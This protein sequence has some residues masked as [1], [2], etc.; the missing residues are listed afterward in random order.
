VFGGG[1]AVSYEFQLTQTSTLDLSNTGMT[2]GAGASG[3]STVDIDQNTRAVLDL[4]ALEDTGEHTLLLARFR[5]IDSSAVR[6]DAKLQSSF[7]LR[8]SRDCAVDGFAYHQNTPL[9]Y[10]RF[11]QAVAYELQWSWPQQK[12]STL[13]G[14]NSVGAYRARLATRTRDHQTVVDKRVVHYEPWRD[15]LGAAMKVEDS[16]ATVEP[17]AGPWFETFEMRENLSGPNGSSKR[18]VVASRVDSPDDPLADQPSAEGEYVWAD[19]L[20][21]DLALPERQPPSKQELK[22]RAEARKLSVDQAVDAYVGRVQDN[23]TGIQDT[24]PQLSIYLEARPEAAAAIVNRVKRAE[25]PQEAVMGAFIALGNARTEEAKDALDG[26]MEDERAPVAARSQAIL[27]L[28]DRDDVGPGLAHSLSANAAKIA[29]GKD[30]HTRI[31]ARQSMLALGAMSGRNPHDPQIKDV[32]V[33]RIS[34]LLGE[35]E[36]PLHLRPVFGALANIGD[37]SLLNLVEPYFAHGDAQVREYAAIAFRRM[38]PAKTGEQA[39]RWLERETNWDVKR[40]LYHTIELQTF[41]ARQITTKGVLRQAVDDLK[42]IPGHVTRKALIRLLARAKEHMKTDTLGIEEVF[43]GLVP[44][45]IEHDTGL[46]LE[47]AEHIDSRKLTP[48]VADAV[49]RAN[50][51]TATAKSQ[52]APTQQPPVGVYPPNQNPTNSHANPQVGPQ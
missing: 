33:A 40:A 8:V 50:S 14:R 13:E 38:P 32:A 16:M 30:L 23:A 6:E 34:Q 11:Q 49:K 35:L 22:A 25:L 28:I 44:Y 4:E 17:G 3:S 51:K 47:L 21:A 20:P 45:E 10:A 5:E 43:L 46:Y 42:A 37:P 26:V 52:A 29:S 18:S 27:A 15:G 24:W 39:A 12:T 31:L 19:L 9:G 7:M 2:R 36:H 1:Q 48:A 41:D